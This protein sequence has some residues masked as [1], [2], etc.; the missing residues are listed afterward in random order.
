MKQN[1]IKEEM[2]L[3][4][5]RKEVNDEKYLKEVSAIVMRMI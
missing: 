1:K 4:N 3:G 5:I 2:K